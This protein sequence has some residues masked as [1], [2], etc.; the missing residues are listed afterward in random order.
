YNYV[1]DTIRDHLRIP[2]VRQCIE[3]LEE[4]FVSKMPVQTTYGNITVLQK[5]YPKGARAIT[6]RDSL[7]AELERV[8]AAHDHA[9]T[10]RDFLLA[11]VERVTAAHDNAIT[12]RDS[13]RTE[14]ER[15]T[16]AQE[17]CQEE[18]TRAI[19]ERD[20]LRTE[21]ERV[22]GAQELCQ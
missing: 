13:L 4:H 17:L 12:E 20:S 14:L 11:E 22:T 15:V 10:E 21:L 7:R 8:T 18:R 2:E 1:N 9:I 3:F 5:R 19:T 6:E 16:G